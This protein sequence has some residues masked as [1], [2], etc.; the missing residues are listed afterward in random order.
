MSYQRFVQNCEMKFWDI[1]TPV[2]SHNGPI[3]KIN[4]FASQLKQ[5]RKHYILV[6]IAVWGIVGFLAGLV[7][8]KVIEMSLLA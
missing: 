1:V 6:L 3:S 2:M 5:N 7:I 8:G 4:V